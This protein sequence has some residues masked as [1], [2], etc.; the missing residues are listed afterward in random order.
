MEKN[1]NINRPKIIE[2]DED[3]SDEFSECIEDDE[4]T[5]KFKDSILKNKT[6][7]QEELLKGPKEV[8]E[9]FEFPVIQE[10]EGNNNNEMII[11]MEQI[12]LDVPLPDVEEGESQ[13]LKFAL[14]QMTSMAGVPGLYKR[15]C[16]NGEGRMPP[17]NS[18]VTVHYNAYLEDEFSTQ[19]KPFDSTV[20]R[21][22]P[23]LF[24]RG[25]G[26]TIEGLDIAVGSMK[27]QE[28]SEFIFSPILAYGSLGCP[29]RIPPNAYV[30]FRIDLIEWVDSS[31]SES[32]G[33]LPIKMRKSLPFSQVLEA[34]KSEKRKGHHQFEKQN[35]IMAGKSYLQALNW[36]QDFRYANEEEERQGTD[37]SLKLHLNLALINL[38][39][40]K[41]KKTCTHCQEALL[42]EPNNI[43]ALYRYGLAKEKLGDFQH[44]KRLLLEAKARSPQ[45]SSITRSLLELSKKTAREADM[46]KNYCQRMMGGVDRN[47]QLLTENESIK[48]LRNQLSKFVIDDAEKELVFSQGL[49]KDE[50]NFLQ[51]QSKNL[52]LKFYVKPSINGNSVCTVSK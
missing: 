44:A 28:Q 37:L 25:Q 8:E 40:N 2:L 19:V 31:A 39:K 18:I 16:R 23:L 43:K 12:T 38:K 51:G 24:M 41:P 1:Q 9:I 33:K 45:D 22:Q 17:P 48:I 36:I 42:I 14:E 50:R 15:I 52:Q 26:A 47:E 46:E 49:T 4:M 3:E 11:K 20:L 6:I 27:I 34:A 30:F 10:N 13:L 21:G 7:F 35:F 29:P 5:L 32:F